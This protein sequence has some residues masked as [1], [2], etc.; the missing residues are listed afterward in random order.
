MQNLVVDIGNSRA[1]CAVVNGGAVEGSWVADSFD[2]LPLEAIVAEYS[3]QRSI[4]CST[5]G[6]GDAAQSRLESIVGHSLLFDTGVPTPLKIDY[7]TLKT[8]GADRVAAAVGVAQLAQGRAA[9]LIDCGTA[10]TIDFISGDGVFC[11]GFISAGLTLRYQALNHYTAALP[12]CSAPQ[13]LHDAHSPRSTQEAIEQGV[14]ASV[15]YEIEGHISHFQRKNRD[16]SIFFIGGDSFH[17][18]KRIKNAI[19]AGQ[20]IIFLALDKILEYNAIK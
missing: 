9:L 12:L 11:G 6:D 1:K 18:E 17:F 10:I 3:P 7:S 14:L 13:T 2:E 16:L 15:I 4:V 5:R 8:L 19:F 20:D